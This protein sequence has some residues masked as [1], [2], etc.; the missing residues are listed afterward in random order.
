MT[1]REAF[2]ASWG[3]AYHA[4]ITYEGEGDCYRGLAAEI[5]VTKYLKRFPDEQ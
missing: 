5:G 3:T 1:S 4:N 2:D